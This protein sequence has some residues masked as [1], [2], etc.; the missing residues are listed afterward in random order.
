MIH[1][2]VMCLIDTQLIDVL[3]KRF[4]IGILREQLVQAMPTDSKMAHDVRAHQIDVRINP[5][6]LDRVIND[7]KQ[8]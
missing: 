1:E 3:G 4:T 2:K 8:F 6:A 7:F 5:L